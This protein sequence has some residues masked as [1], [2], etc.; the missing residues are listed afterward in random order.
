MNLLFKS[1]RMSYA[2]QQFTFAVTHG[3][4]QFPNIIRIFQVASQS[5]ENYL[6]K[7]VNVSE[8]ERWSRSLA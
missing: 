5:M 1:Q 6:R 2:N 8:E 7:S 4:A 3:P